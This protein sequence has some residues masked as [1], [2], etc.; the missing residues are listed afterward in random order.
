MDVRCDRCQTEYEL[1]DESVADAGASVQCTTCGHT[2]VV[3]RTGA[4][5][6]TSVVSDVPAPD[7]TMPAPPDWI[8]ST[9]EGQTHRF[10]E[11]T[12]LQ[13]WI[14]ERRVTRE[15]RVSHRG[16]PWRR[17]GDVDELRPFFSVVDQ[18]DR[19]QS[20]DMERALRSTQPA[21][22]RRSPNP[23]HVPEPVEGDGEDGIE[24]TARNARRDVLADEA[25]FDPDEAL[26]AAGIAGR[27]RKAKIA[28]GAAIGLLAG[29][30]FFFLFKDPH[31]LRLAGK[32]EAPGAPSTAFSAT[33]APKPSASAPVAAPPAVAPVAP[34]AP[35]VATARMPA[36]PAAPQPPVEAAQGEPAKGA[37]PEPPK[38]RTYEHLV[39][40]ADRALEN[41]AT[42]KAQKLYDEALKLQPEGVAAITGS[43]YL[44]LD[45]NRTLAAIGLFKRA[46]ISAPSFPPA[47]FG[48][49][50]A[51]R[52]HGDNAAAIEAYK[53][54]LA[55]APGGADA[56]AARRQVKELG[57]A[58]QQ[59]PQAA[60]AGASAPAQQ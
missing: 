47:L 6:V 17:L 29:G 24:K 22:S 46:L 38:P 43:A 40:E 12:T 55:A 48:L 11:P 49:G 37:H 2:F 50:E 27:R 58:A 13:K 26:A 23:A 20:A 51:Y 14:V 9:H 60:S 15:D 16:G 25:A 28:G 5:I 59:P 42:S 44:L 36:S 34:A 54:Y 32:N 35:P 30:A 21:G 7:Y 31:A 53:R 41:G 10:R 33:S 56:P 3:S 19:A 57:E 18:A 45:R 39:A 1:D 52:A 4:T 8:L